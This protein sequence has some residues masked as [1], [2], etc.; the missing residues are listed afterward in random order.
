MSSSCQPTSARP[1]V[2]EVQIATPL[3]ST[4]TRRALAGQVVLDQRRVRH[5][6]ARGGRRRSRCGRC[7]SARSPRAAARPSAPA[8]PARSGPRRPPRATGAAPG[9]HRLDALDR[10]PRRLPGCSRA[11]ASDA[12]TWASNTRSSRDTIASSSAPLGQLRAR[13]GGAPDHR[14]RRRGH[15]RHAHQLAA[16]ERQCPLGLGRG[17]ASVAWR[18]INSGAAERRARFARHQHA[19]GRRPA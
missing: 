11:A 10:D 15:D 13:L 16:R 18:S 4:R 6:D 7:R 8:T 14:A 17:A 5:A 1:S 3:V 2:T 12:G 19:D 9:H